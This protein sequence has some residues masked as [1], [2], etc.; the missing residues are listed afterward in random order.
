MHQLVNHII[1]FI[2]ILVLSS[3]GETSQNEIS[4]SYE[5]SKTL[6]IKTNHL[7]NISIFRNNFGV[8]NIHGKTD[9]DV[10]FGIGY[11]QSEDNFSQLELAFIISTG[12]ATEI[13]GEQ[14]I[15]S[16]WVVHSFENNEISKRDYENASNQVKTLLEGYAHGINYYIEKHPN[17]DSRLLDHIEP[18]YA[19]AVIR[20]RYY[21]G[22]FFGPNG[23]THE[24][25]KSAFKA[26]NGKRIKNRM[27]EIP[28]YYPEDREIFDLMLTSANSSYNEW[29][30]HSY[31]DPHLPGQAF[32][33]L[34]GSDTGWNFNGSI[35]FGY[36]LPYIGFNEKFDWMSNNKIELEQSWTKYFQ[37]TKNALKY[38]FSDSL[39]QSTKWSN[40][41]KIREFESLTLK[42]QRTRLGAIVA[43]RDGQL[44]SA[45]YIPNNKTSLIDQ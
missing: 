35:R 22:R 1:I 6:E 43:K 41:I 36:P 34:I 32:E 44:L 37:E 19:L 38:R 10:A 14:A 9:R 33:V 21:I 20:R 31:S 7:Q 16:D 8:S 25:T 4:P 28:D 30:L 2:F 40:T 13:L 3:C 24:E 42:Y 45:N 23:F 18:W 27:I 26:I 5:K 29:D 11:A 15:L 17:L 12:R 39:Q